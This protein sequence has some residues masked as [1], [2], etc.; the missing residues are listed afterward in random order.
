MLKACNYAVEDIC[1]ILKT[2]R[3]LDSFEELKELGSAFS[4]RVRS[5]NEGQLGESPPL[6]SQ[7]RLISTVEL[8]KPAFLEANPYLAG[9]NRFAF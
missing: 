9:R 6:L 8:I 2:L 4:S 3:K 5:L 7:L 1:E